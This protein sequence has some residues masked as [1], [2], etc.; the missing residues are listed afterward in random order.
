MP[1]GG[2]EVGLLRSPSRFTLE[3][4]DIG[5][6]DRPI[7]YR[8]ALDR[9]AV[10]AADW[11]SCRRGDVQVRG[12]GSRRV[13]HRHRATFLNM[14]NDRFRQAQFAGGGQILHL[15]AFF[16]SAQSDDAP[17]VL[18]DNRIR[19]CPAAH[20]KER[21]AQQDNANSGSQNHVR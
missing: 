13:A 20:G 8:G 2:I 9:V 11:L 7:V 14:I 4:G 12:I 3:L 5:A 21:D 10:P 18:Q 15:V 16:D 1:H 17:A 19:H 6:V